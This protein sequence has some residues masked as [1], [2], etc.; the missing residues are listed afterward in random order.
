MN[1]LLDNDIIEKPKNDA[2]KISVRTFLAAIDRLEERINLLTQRVANL[3]IE[4]WRKER[5]FNK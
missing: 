1:V 2:P 4:A 5:G 3:E